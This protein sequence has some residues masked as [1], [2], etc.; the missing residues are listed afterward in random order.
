MITSNVTGS[1][2]RQGDS[3]LY[4]APVIAMERIM[5]GHHYLLAALKTASRL[6]EEGISTARRKVDEPKD[7]TGELADPPQ[8]LDEHQSGQRR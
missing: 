2:D 1:V 4:D 7:L 6:P 3:N 8:G 5:Q